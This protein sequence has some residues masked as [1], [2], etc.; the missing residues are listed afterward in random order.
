MF[1]KRVADTSQTPAKLCLY[2]HYTIQGDKNGNIY[3]GMSLSM[4]K[5]N[6]IDNIECLQEF[7]H[8]KKTS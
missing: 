5:K 1:C 6:R 3:I 7:M 2:L 4:N 8:E